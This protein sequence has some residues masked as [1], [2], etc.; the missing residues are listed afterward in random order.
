MKKKIIATV[1]A[2]TMVFGTAFSI[3]AYAEDAETTFDETV[4]ASYDA[5]VVKTG[6][7]GENVKWTLDADGTLT[8]K[9][10]GKIEFGTDN[11]M[12][13]TRDI[14]K[15]V[16][17]DGVTSICAGAFADCSLL[18]EVTI[19]DSVVFIGN[20][21]FSS[22][23]WLY[24]KQKEDPFVI[25]NG[26]LIDGHK[27]S[28][29]IV[30]PDGVTAIGDCAFGSN[31]RITGAT[32]PKSVV[33]IGFMAFGF[34]TSL[35]NVKMNDGLT[36]IG[37]EAFLHCAITEI[38]IPASVKTMGSRAF[39]ECH[40]ME[41]AV[42][43][44]GL[45]ELG[46]QAFWMCKKLNSLNIPKSV[47][48]IGDLCFNGCEALTTVTIPDGVTKIGDSM[49]SGCSSLTSVDI[50][51]SVTSIDEW[52]FYNCENL[53][54][55]TIPESV[56]KFGRNAFSTAFWDGSSHTYETNPMTISG[57]KGSAAEKYANK[58]GFK[59]IEL[60]KSGKPDTKTVSK[61]DA[62]GDSK[63]NVA[64]IAA[65][66]SYIKGIKALTGDGLK[67][68]DVNG[69][70]NVNVADIAMIASHIKGI[71]ALS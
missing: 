5:A 39:A 4:T 54:N 27:C 9:G 28:G 59:F 38:S 8:I 57:Y 64:D 7:C 43:H 51:D 41:K 26:I 48:V 56:A 18:E 68:A 34:C 50:P 71:K 35:K 40:Y 45:T 42:L 20:D 61:G 16:I 11:V 31:E 21:A 19:P 2:V 63:V 30:I 12:P 15:L 6:K 23:K 14:K 13:W 44:E 25:V 49:F 66:A 62:N 58:N 36:S 29:D 17:G 46:V 55:I 60:N 3:S 67:A 69:D 53:K 33:N 32:F 10:S 22:T 47:N 65:I 1:M 24:Q 52:A 70:G 37:E